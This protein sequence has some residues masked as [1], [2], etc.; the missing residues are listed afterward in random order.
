MARGEERPLEDGG[1]RVPGKKGVLLVKSEGP[2]GS[3][4]LERWRARARAAM[5]PDLG[6]PLED[7]VEWA[8]STVGSGSSRERVAGLAEVESL[9]VFARKEAASLDEGRAL[10][11]LGRAS[12]IAEDL[13]DVPG[14]AAW[15]AEI[16]I[17]I[18]ITA[19]QAGREDLAR[20]AFSRAMVLDPSRGV[21]AAEAPPRVVELAAQ[22][23]REASLRPTGSFVVT[24]DPP[25]ARV[26]LDDELVGT[27]PV[28]VRGSIGVHVL[29]LERPGYASYGRLFDMVEGAS[30]EWTVKLSPL[31]AL[32]A[33]RELVRASST[34]DRNAVVASLARLHAQG[35]HLDAW[36]LEVGEGPRDRALLHA[37][38]AEGCSEPIRQEAGA[39][40]ASP[41]RL[42]AAFDG[43]RER[44]AE[45]W[46][47]RAPLEPP[48][49][50]RDTR[51]LRWPYW[52]A[53]AAVGVAAVAVGVWLLRPEPTPRL[54]TVITLPPELAD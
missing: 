44:E 18:G 49:E 37:C 35:L 41:P 6:D 24:S 46:L 30:A 28:T 52:V 27:T 45:A 12:R 43:S 9:L 3:K 39:T 36:L 54:R 13:A 23:A 33:A 17:A 14:A 48:P 26:F 29:R 38:F 34:G 5:A 20:A 25:G 22:I 51:R 2:R 47:L 31:E 21:R 40:F 19:M 1:S 32:V 7:P 16:E 10:A 15:L 50:R 4:R 11:A 53:T 8:E 42:P